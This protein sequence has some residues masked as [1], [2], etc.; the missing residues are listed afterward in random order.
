MG[1]SED[2]DVEEF[3]VHEKYD[4]RDKFSANIARLQLKRKIQSLFDKTGVNA[5]CLPACDHQFSDTFKNQTGTRCWIAGFGRDSDLVSKGQESDYSQSL[6]KI[7]V[8]LYQDRDRCTKTMQNY[9]IG[10][11]G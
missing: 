2:Y 1:S 10:S 4:T 8:P 7:D 9:L 3:R 6:R 5:A 11:Q